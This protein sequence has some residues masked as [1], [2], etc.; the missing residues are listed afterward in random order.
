MNIQ[1]QA[2]AGVRYRALHVDNSSDGCL[3][4]LGRAFPVRLLN[5]GFDA[6]SR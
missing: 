3:P 5:A 1:A 6:A 4:G 2:G